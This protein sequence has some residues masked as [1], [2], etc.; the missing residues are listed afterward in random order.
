MKDDKA[1]LLLEYQRLDLEYEVI[2][3]LVAEFR[4]KGKDFVADDL[5]E[6]LD[7]LYK[8]I[9]SIKKAWKF[10]DAPGFYYEQIKMDL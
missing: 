7:F 3:D 10:A 4:E 5:K 2:R 9:L 1:R 6:A 8:A